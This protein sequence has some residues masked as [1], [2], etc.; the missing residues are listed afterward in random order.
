MVR[1]VLAAHAP[2]AARFRLRPR[3]PSARAWPPLRAGA[4]ASVAAGHL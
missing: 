2:R 4:A 3:G 1:A